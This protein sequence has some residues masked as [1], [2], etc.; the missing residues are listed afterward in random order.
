MNKHLRTLIG[1]ARQAK[2]INF[3]ELAELCGF[4]PL[5]WANRIVNFEREGVGRDKMIRKLIQSLELD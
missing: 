4:N 5:K 2:G 1:H 3:R